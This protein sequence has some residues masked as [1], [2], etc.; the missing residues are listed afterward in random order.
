MLLSF[1]AGD[2]EPGARG[3]VEAHLA[4][5]CAACE[6]ELAA[7]ADLRRI[8][9]SDALEHPPA[10]VLARA[11]RIP[12]AGRGRSVA[13]L[14][15]ALAALVFDTLSDPLPRGA[16]AAGAP[17]R[18]ML[19]RAL[20]YDIDVRVIGA[21]PGRVRVSGQILPGAA[22]PIDAV[23]GLEVALLDA[24]TFSVATTNELGEF[25]F[26]PR[27]EGDYTLSVETGEERLL[28]D[29]LPAH[30]T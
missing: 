11:Q 12:E 6:R 15:G 24:S 27:D 4:G 23:A 30:S 17:S 21:G 3:P 20:D 9:R 7:F 8:A 1:A 14:A 25:D 5:G 26:G 18:Q 29:P 2:L 16:R 22:R 13:R 10:A 28:V 19:F